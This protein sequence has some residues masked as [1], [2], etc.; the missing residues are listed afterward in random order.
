MESLPSA[1]GFHVGAHHS[2]SCIANF[3]DSSFTDYL[4][5]DPRHTLGA[6]GYASDIY[7]IDEV[8]A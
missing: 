3:V 4:V 2:L 6:N 8:L 5:I 1:R 7:R